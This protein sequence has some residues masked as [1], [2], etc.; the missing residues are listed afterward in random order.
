MSQP[1]VLSLCARC[2][3]GTRKNHRC[4]KPIY[5][6]ITASDIR[7]YHCKHFEPLREA[8]NALSEKVCRKKA[9]RVGHFWVCDCGFKELA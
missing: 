8:W 5:G 7:L 6:K 9:V 3:W 4:S 1:V 2:R